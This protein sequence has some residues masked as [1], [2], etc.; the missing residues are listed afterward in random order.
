MAQLISKAQAGLAELVIKDESRIAMQGV[1]VTAKYAEVT[2]GHYLV[3]IP[4]PSMN[5]S[6]ADFPAVPGM[7]NGSKAESIIP[8]QPL[9]DAVKGLKKTAIPILEYIHLGETKDG[10]TLTTTD[11]ETPS[12]RTVKPIDMQFPACD[13]VIPEI[14]KDKPTVCLSA[15]Y[16][17]ALATY[18]VKHGRGNAPA[19]R[20]YIKDAES[21]V[22]MEFAL[23]EGDYDQF[24]TIVLMPIRP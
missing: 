1:H 18:V 4:A 7:G 8:A 20:L 15:A 11:L 14:E 9:K 16:L 19:I 17:K 2:N 22:R 6:L 3:R 23:E 24:G 21:P 10:M 13:K 12:V 5:Q